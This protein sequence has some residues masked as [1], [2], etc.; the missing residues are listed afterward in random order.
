MTLS[1][2]VLAIRIV[3]WFM[4]LFVATCGA[5]LCQNSKMRKTVKNIAHLPSPFKTNPKV[6]AIPSNAILTPKQLEQ[7]LASIANVSTKNRY[8]I[9]QKYE[10][11]IRRDEEK[12]KSVRWHNFLDVIE[13]KAELLK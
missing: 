4:I 9:P 6:Y 1:T 13:E 3:I 5:S 7:E 11:W 10:R 2:L 12:E 8:S